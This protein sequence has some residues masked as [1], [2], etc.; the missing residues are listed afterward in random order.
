LF[1]ADARG[2]D[3][4]MMKFDPK[5]DVRLRIAGIYFDDFFPFAELGT[6]STR[7]TGVKPSGKPTIL[8]LLEVAWKR[9]QSAVKPVNEK[10]LFEYGI[11]RR[12]EKEGLS[13]TS[14][15]I[16]HTNPIKKSIGNN[17]RPAGVYTLSE[18]EFPNGVVAWQYYVIRN[19]ISISQYQPLPFPTSA[20][21]PA[22]VTTGAGFTP[23]SEKVLEAGD[24]VIWRQVAILRGPVA[25]PTPSKKP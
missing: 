25:P 1:D 13:I 7:I 2:D 22:E 19:G 8:E 6:I 5:K 24:Q 18:F 3:M 10:K 12:P 17:V 16:E 20:F 14:F 4:S 11:L 21:S 9:Y 15:S 23:F